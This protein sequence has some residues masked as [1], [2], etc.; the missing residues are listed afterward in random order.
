M[1]KERKRTYASENE[2]AEQIS[3]AGDIIYFKASTY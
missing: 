2:S 1:V 3:K